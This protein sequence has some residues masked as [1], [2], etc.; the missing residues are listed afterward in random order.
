MNKELI[1]IR[2]CELVGVIACIMFSGCATVKVGELELDR[3]AA[4]HPMSPDIKKSTRTILDTPFPSEKLIGKWEGE[5]LVQEFLWNLN[6]NIKK[7][8]VNKFRRILEFK[9]DG[10][11]TWTE[12]KNGVKLYSSVGKWK[13]EINN[14]GIAELTIQGLANPYWCIFWYGEG[15]FAFAERNADW[16]AN[17]QLAYMKKKYDTSWNLSCR[18]ERDRWGNEKYVSHHI[19]GGGGH[20]RE[21]HFTP[22]ILR[23]VSKN[24]AAA[25]ILT[26]P[27]VPT[28]NIQTPVPEKVSE[29]AQQ[30]TSGQVYELENI[31]L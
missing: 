1:S 20:R 30:D 19:K 8:P 9:A 11:F 23:R 12:Y 7:F 14:F 24:D 22:K 29:P 5:F 4:L 21:I 2:L 26:S 6:G 16:A 31:S 15:E 27:S 28:S 25:G 10:G 13:Y 18:Y 3:I 17:N